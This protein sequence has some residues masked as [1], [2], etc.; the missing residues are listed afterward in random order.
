MAESHIVKNLADKRKEITAY[1]GSLEQDLEQ[2]LDVSV[3]QTRL[4]RRK[5]VAEGRRALEGIVT[6]TGPKLDMYGEP[7]PHYAPPGR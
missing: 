2:T 4:A 7:Q 3:S 1:V 5:A 6:L